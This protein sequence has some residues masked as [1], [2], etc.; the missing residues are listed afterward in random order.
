MASKTMRTKEAKELLQALCD[1]N[2]PVV[3]KDLLEDLCTPREMGEMTQRLH[4]ARLLDAGT[5]YSAIQRK[6]GASATTIARVSRALNHGPGGYAH[7]LHP[8]GRNQTK[9][10]NE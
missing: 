3:M 9:G 8:K 1:I 2:D 5:N 10:G 4:V 7:V 6:T